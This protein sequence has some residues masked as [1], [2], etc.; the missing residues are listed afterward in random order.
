MF[1]TLRN[2]APAAKKQTTSAK[3]V[4]LI[5]AA[6]FLVI[7]S[8]IFL[9]AG[10]DYSSVIKLENISEVSG[11]LDEVYVSDEGDLSLYLEGDDK[12]YYIATELYDTVEFNSSNKLR[13]GDNLSM[14]VGKSLMKTTYVIK[15]TKEGLPLISIEVGHEHYYVESIILYA[16][17]VICAIAAIIF[18]V[19][20]VKKLKKAK[21]T[22]HN[23]DLL[24]AIAEEGDTVLWHKVLTAKDMIATMYAPFGRIMLICAAT[25]LVFGLASDVN[26][27]YFA[28]FFGIVF[29]WSAAILCISAI[30]PTNRHIYVVTDK[31]IVVSLPAMLLFLN[32]EDI[33]EIKLKKS[34]LLKDKATLHFIPNYKASVKYRFVL[35]ENAEDIKRLIVSRIKN[36]SEF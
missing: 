7:F 30:I 21:K 2:T 29:V 15:L 14:T 19:I 16:L 27:A 35:I 8:I 17:G 4:L 9:L 13:K 34:L 36:E 22:L 3:T 31:R 10:F 32:F 1:Q 23:T 18:V 26:L 12:E 28:I 25:G 6:I 20:F 24:E 5:C 33:K 11:T